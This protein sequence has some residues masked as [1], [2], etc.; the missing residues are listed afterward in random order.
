MRACL[1]LIAIAQDEARSTHRSTPGLAKSSAGGWNSAAI[2]EFVYVFNVYRVM[3]LLG[4][5][6]R[7]TP[8]AT[9][10]MLREIFAGA[11][12]AHPAQM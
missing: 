2:C 7:F 8:W 9:V 6:S 1:A 5:S 4:G 12:P 11:L 10:Y 3:I